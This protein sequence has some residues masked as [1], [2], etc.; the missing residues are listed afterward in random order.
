VVNGVGWFEEDQVAIGI[1]S[2]AVKVE[3]GP[4][5]PGRLREDRVRRYVGDSQLWVRTSSSL[6][7]RE[8]TLGP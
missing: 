1:A 4:A 3:G 5:T 2:D 8:E 7:A 6:V